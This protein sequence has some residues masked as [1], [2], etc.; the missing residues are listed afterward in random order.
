M[1]KINCCAALFLLFFIANSSFG[2]LKKIDVG[3]EKGLSLV[4]M[5]GN[6]VLNDFQKSK[7]S[8]TIGVFFQY[9]LNAN[10]ALRSNISFE[11]KGFASGP[12]TGYDSIG[13]PTTVKSISRFDYLC[14]Q[15][16]QEHTLERN[17]GFLSMQDHMSVTWS[18]RLI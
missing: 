12:H 2:Q 5:R 9:N 17:T 18:A 10:F 1:R 16:W 3:Y 15:S 13:G 6:F 4:S 11:R 14:C 8:F 7:L